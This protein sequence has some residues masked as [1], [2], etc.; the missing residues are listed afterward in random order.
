MKTKVME[1][2]NRN[3]IE[4]EISYDVDDYRKIDCIDFYTP[5]GYQFEEDLHSRC[6]AD[7]WDVSAKDIWEFIYNDM[8]KNP[9]IKCDDNCN[10]RD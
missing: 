3:N 6:F 1:Y 2:V 7:L 4:M 9:I 8:C 5:N 10:C